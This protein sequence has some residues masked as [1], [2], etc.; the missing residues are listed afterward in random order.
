MFQQPKLTT[1]ITKMPKTTTQTRAK[2]IA[3]TTSPTEF[4]PPHFQ[5]LE[6]ENHNT[7][8]EKILEFANN[9][10]QR[11]LPKIQ[12]KVKPLQLLGNMTLINQGNSPRI[13]PSLSPIGSY[14]T[15]TSELPNVVV[16]LVNFL[17]K[18]Q[19]VCKI[20]TSHIQN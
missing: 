17:K 8:M 16:K 19:Q 14:S 10:F 11:L 18:Q 5:M 7:T 6:N 4:F 2:T 3:K 13:S 12:I 9:S 1:T 15:S 20:S